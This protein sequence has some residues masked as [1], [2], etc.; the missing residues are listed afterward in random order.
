MSRAPPP[1]DKE[2]KPSTVVT[3]ETNSSSVTK[4][5]PRILTRT[6]KDQRHP[7]GYAMQYPGLL[8]ARAW[9]IHDSAF[10]QSSA[11]PSRQTRSYSV[12]SY[13][14]DASGKVV[15]SQPASGPRSDPRRSREAYEQI[16]T[17]MSGPGGPLQ[18][19]PTETLKL[20]SDNY[21]LEDNDARTYVLVSQLPPHA[22]E[23]IVRNFFV[24]N[25]GPLRKLFFPSHPETNL[26]MDFAYAQFY[27]SKHAQDAADLNGVSFRPAYKRP[28][29]MTIEF[30]P[31]MERYKAMYEKRSR[32]KEISAPIPTNNAASAPSRMSSSANMMTTNEGLQSQLSSKPTAPSSNQLASNSAKSNHSETNGHSHPQATQLHANGHS[33]GSNLVEQEAAPPLQ[34]LYPASQ[35]RSSESIPLSSGL[36]SS[37]DNNNSKSNAMDIVEEPKTAKREEISNEVSLLT[38]SELQSTDT[39][40]HSPESSSKEADAIDHGK[41]SGAKVPPKSTKSKTKTTALPTKPK[42]PFI[43]VCGPPPA[44]SAPKRPSKSKSSLSAPSSTSSTPASRTT[45]PSLA[46]PAAKRQKLKEGAIFAPHPSSPSPYPIS[47]LSPTLGSTDTSTETPYYVDVVTTVSERAPASN[48][49][50]RPNEEEFYARMALAQWEKR[51]PEV[52]ADLKRTKLDLEKFSKTSS[53]PE[54]AALRKSDLE[55]WKHFS[56]TWKSSE[57]LNNAP[58]YHL[59][60]KSEMQYVREFAPEEGFV[61]SPEQKHALK[62]GYDLRFTQSGSARTEGPIDLTPEEKRRTRHRFVFEEEMAS[63]TQFTSD[64]AGG[65]SAGSALGA[66]MRARQ[67][68]Q[69]KRIYSGVEVNT[70]TTRKKRLKFGRSTIHDWGLYAMEFIPADDVVI[71]YVGD[72]IRPKIADEREKKYND[73]GIGSSY[74]FRIDDDKVIDATTMGNL[75]RFLN[76]HCDPNCYAKIIP[77]A[78]SKRIVIYSKRDIQAGEEVTYDYKFPL[79]PEELKVKCLCGAAKCR[80]NLN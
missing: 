77:F 45:D 59:G 68:R 22:T 57:R 28:I 38:S 36:K 46:A 74:L 70:L 55:L 80:G 72:I 40:V 66:S 53:A 31:K 69:D 1:F 27:F 37:L 33:N 75:A 23:E 7:E 42:R 30:D 15:S 18:L 16:V 13:D 67:S 49:P 50:V 62:L 5:T 41:D 11:D 78:Q 3:S 44:A 25:V 76:H 35:D 19:P 4:A 34:R 8:G 47:T 2:K 60:P 79:E 65:A 24:S 43:L 63:T 29:Q 64:S 48:D 14:T 58:L 12:D 39:S 6:V 26:G 10:S 73:Q 17:L 20:A 51:H 71:E 54:S 61:F 9:R 52:S 32:S 56:E 21:T